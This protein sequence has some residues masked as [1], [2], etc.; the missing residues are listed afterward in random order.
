MRR[1]DE[2]APFDPGLRGQGS[3]IPPAPVALGEPAPSTMLIQHPYAR[4]VD[5]PVFAADRQTLKMISQS[6]AAVVELTT[7]LGGVCEGAVV[8]VDREP[9]HERRVNEPQACPA[10]S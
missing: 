3:A 1:P 7:M 2:R 6:S 5:G 9:G 4:A 10:R 8:S